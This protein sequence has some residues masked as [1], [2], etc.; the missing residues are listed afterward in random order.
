MEDDSARIFFCANLECRQLAIICRSCDRGNRYC[1]N[2]CACLARRK[3]QRRASSKY[4]QSSTGR[5]HHAARQEAYRR[6]QLEKVTHQ[7]SPKEGASDN[8]EPVAINEGIGIAALKL[9][10]NKTSELCCCKCGLRCGPYLR[11]DFWRRGRCRVQK[12]GGKT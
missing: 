1:S 6:R 7:G 8:V 11:R 12:H 3:A 5:L 4:Q 9:H 10:T 2:K